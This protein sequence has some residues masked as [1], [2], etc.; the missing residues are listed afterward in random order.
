MSAPA[1]P[2]LPETAPFSP[3]Q[4][5]WL[6]GF[7]AGMLACGN[8]STATPAPPAPKAVEEDF[9]WH[10]STLSL[11]DRLK[12]AEGRKPERVLMAA[13]AQL[14]CGACGYLCKTYAEAI[15][16]GNEKDLNKCS[17]GG[18]PT[19]SKLREL[20][21]L[22]V[23]SGTSAAAT[24]VVAPEPTNLEKHNRDNP[25][26]APLLVSR[27]LN[28]ADSEK[29][30]RHVEIG[31]KGSTLA[32]KA[33]DALGIWPE[34]C[35]DLVNG[36]LQRLDAS[37]AEEAKSID[38]RPTSL[39][40]ALLRE[41]IIT[42]PTE[43]LIELL[44]QYAG[45]PHERSHLQA[46]LTEEGGEHLEG[47]HVL[48]ILQLVPSSKPPINYFVDSLGTLQPR[49]YSIASSPKAHAQQV[50]LTV[51]AV[52][53]VNRKGRRVTGVAS[54]YLADRVRPGEKLR[55]FVHESKNFA[56]PANPDVPIIMIGPGTGIAPFR[57]FLHD[58][59]ANGAKG[60]NWLFFGDQR[61]TC[62]Y[63]YGDE[64]ES[65]KNDGHLTHLDTAF[66]RDQQH[67]VYV[68]HRM[69]ERSREMWKWID[70]GAHI[71]VCGD[72][73]RMASD[74]DRALNEIISKEAG[75][76]A[77]AAKKQLSEMAAKGRYQRDV[78]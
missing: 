70:E 3:S 78:Y 57:A 43:A 12:M 19:A 45:D 59:Q 10:D 55:V 31:I 61:S 6:N 72:A 44:V 9:P 76:P 30:V 62:D 11:S 32:Y 28:G 69:Q 33:G 63:L 29:E 18:A 13:M 71:Y 24:P 15:A 34:N 23:K 64:L 39:F 4:R 49:L 77:E 2:F 52:R 75:L 73:R 27:R 17:P 37:G 74:V 48:D 53:Y 26:R 36:I 50:H 7:L 58:R 16:S 42:Q 22:N 67:K 35:L 54:T 41:R 20:V 47:L 38:G 8:S 21:K 25:F 51:G 60:R 68:Q 40:D 1:I 56:L 65:F 46:M 66:S 14:D 5:A